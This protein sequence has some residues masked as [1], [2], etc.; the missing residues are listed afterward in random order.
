[1]DSSATCSF[2]SKNRLTSGVTCSKKAVDGS[3]L[4]ASHTRY[5]K[6]VEKKKAKFSSDAWSGFHSDSS[7]S[8]ME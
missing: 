7:H 4:C 8:D 6:A 5:V 3:D 1:M 2:K